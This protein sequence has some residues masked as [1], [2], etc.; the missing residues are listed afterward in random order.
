MTEW[1]E[2]DFSSQLTELLRKSAAYGGHKLCMEAELSREHQTNLL[3]KM[4]F[5]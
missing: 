2:T 3:C 1:G 4:E 5:N